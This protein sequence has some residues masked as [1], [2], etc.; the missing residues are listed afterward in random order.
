MIK[1]FCPLFVVCPKLL[2][3]NKKNELWY[4]KKK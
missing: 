2:N 3:V 1:N 4:D